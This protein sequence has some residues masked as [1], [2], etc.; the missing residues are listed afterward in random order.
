MVLRYRHGPEPVSADKTHQREFFAFKEVLNNN[1]GTCGAE[2]IADENVVQGLQ[3]GI[4]IHRNCNT[5]AGRQPV[6]F[7]HHR[8]PMLFNIS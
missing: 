5:F 2:L 4:R 3:G 8:R 7:Y 1:A 6:R